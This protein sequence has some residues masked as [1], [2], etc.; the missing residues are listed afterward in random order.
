MTAHRLEHCGKAGV[1]IEDQTVHEG[2]K[3]FIRNVPEASDAFPFWDH[4]IVKVFDVRYVLYK[5]TGILTRDCHATAGQ[6]SHF[7]RIGEYNL[8]HDNL[9]PDGSLP[10]RKPQLFFTGINVYQPFDRK[11]RVRAGNSISKPV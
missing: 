8:A 3:A 10:E 9:S 5:G 11:N 4:I 2:G 6:F 1:A 7:I